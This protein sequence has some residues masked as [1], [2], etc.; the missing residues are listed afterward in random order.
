M[1]A[2]SF[3]KA[4]MMFVVAVVLSVATTVSAQD[5][6]AAPSPTMDTGAAFSL[7]IS[8][9]AVIL[10]PFVSLLTLMKQ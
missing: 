5:T 2:V 4:I 9:V 7:P 1:A 10:S 8:G 6:A 3:S